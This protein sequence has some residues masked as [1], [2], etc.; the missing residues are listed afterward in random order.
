MHPTVLLEDGRLGEPLPTEVTA[1]RPL[2]GVDQQVPAQVEAVGE[3]PAAD[4]AAEL[5]LDRV[6]VLLPTVASQLGGSGEHQL[7]VPTRV[8]AALA[9][10]LLPVLRVQREAGERQTTGR[11]LQRRRARPRPGVGL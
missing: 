6:R 4:A 1:E 8:V 5:L 11:A 2:P 10:V 7:T 3:V 9:V